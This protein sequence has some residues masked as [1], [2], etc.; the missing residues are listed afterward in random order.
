MR[1]HIANATRRSWVIR[2]RLMPRASWMP[3][4]RARISRWVVTSSA[5]V[6]SSAISTL[7]VAGQRGGDP[8]SLAHP[9][10]E[11]ERVAVGH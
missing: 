3:L 9:A 2:I 1:S 7:R 11:L 6:G 4:I 10:G 8:D 5:V